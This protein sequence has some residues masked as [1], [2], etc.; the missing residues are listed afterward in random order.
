MTERAEEGKNVLACTVQ[1]LKRCLFRTCDVVMSR[2]VAGSHKLPHT[3]ADCDCTRVYI[4]LGV[5][6]NN[7]G[8]RLMKILCV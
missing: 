5:M 4:Q 3:S 8:S 1:P 7:S 6:C 2:L